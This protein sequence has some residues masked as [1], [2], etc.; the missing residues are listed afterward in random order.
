MRC[1]LANSI[2]CFTWP[3]VSDPVPTTI[4]FTIISSIMDSLES[5]DPALLASVIVVYSNVCF[6]RLLTCYVSTPCW[7]LTTAW[8]RP[9]ANLWA[10]A[11]SLHLGHRHRQYLQTL[12]ASEPIEL[13]ASV[14]LYLDWPTISVSTYFPMLWS[15]LTG[16][17]RHSHFGGLHHWPTLG[18]SFTS[19]SRSGLQGK[20]INKPRKSKFCSRRKI[21][22]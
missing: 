4:A 3:L 19:A 22:W 2:D 20:A 15:M 18:S 5:K 13:G 21:V 1:P 17:P 16:L 12:K 7:S 9:F 8:L 10:P 6:R 11:L 14:P